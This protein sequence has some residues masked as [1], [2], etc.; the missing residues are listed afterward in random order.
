[1]APLNSAYLDQFKYNISAYIDIFDFLDQISSK[2][3]FPV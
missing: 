3:V 2:R 1:M